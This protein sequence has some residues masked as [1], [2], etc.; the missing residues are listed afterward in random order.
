[1]PT[2]DAGS[3]LDGV[4]VLVLGGDVAARA[5]RVLA[6]LGADVVRL[7]D[8]ERGDPLASRRS[9]WLAWSAGTTVGPATPEE[10]AAL[11]ARADVVIDTPHDDATIV[12]DCATAAPDAVWVRITPFGL[13]GPRAHW[14]ATDHGIMAASGNMYSTGDPS[15]PP[16]HAAEP[17]SHAHS[18]GEAAYAAIAAL[19]SGRPQIIDL[20]MQECV[21]IA[22]MGAIGRYEREGL[23]GSRGGAKI[24]TTREIWRAQDGFVS[25]G[26]R[27]GK[28]RQASMELISKLVRDAGIDEPAL[29]QDWATWHQNR[30][31]AEQLAAMERA[32]GAYFA[33]RTMQE[34]YDIACETNLMLAPANSPKEVY[35]SRQLGARGFFQPL[36]D[37]ARF[38]TPFVHVHRAAPS[39][40][41]GPPRVT[42]RTPLF[43]GSGGHCAPDPS[44]REQPVWHGTRIIEFGSGAAGP[45]ATRYFVE[46]GATVLRV[47]SPSR[48]DF[49]RAMAVGAP[50]NP[51][52]LEGAGMYDSLNCAKRH[53]TLNL[54]HPDAVALVKRLVAEWADAV[55]ENYAPKAMKG[56]GLDYDALAS[57]KPDLVMISACLNGQTGP[58]KDYPGFGGQGSALSGWNWITGWPDLEPVGPFGTITDSLAPRYVA[59]ALA[60]GLLRRQRTGRGCYLDLAQVEAG[61][62][63]LSPWL[64]DHELDG[65]IGM[66]RGNA[67][68]D[69]LV[70]GVYPSVDED[71]VGDRWV[72]IACWTEAQRDALARVIAGPPADDA[73]SA[74]T[75]WRTRLDAAE[76]LQAAGVE[77]VPVQDFGDLQTDPQVLHRD[78]FVARTHPF[79]GPGRYERNGTRFSDATTGYDRAGPTFGQDNAWVLGELLGLSS[80][81]IDALRDS[82]AM[83]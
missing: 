16:L 28:A 2:D 34:L 78:H 13:D 21:F 45:I 59:T 62:W 80:A 51:H 12:L 39:R 56:F 18:A 53:V 3:L 35:A 66:R 65:T 50:G 76:A 1:M 11:A 42:D 17:T 43:E 10:A 19:A 57:V 60:A 31:P 29:D 9:A 67:N 33:T 20:S 58:H 27:G 41:T 6:D 5:G 23:R 26:I 75:S 37:V 52:G 44:H 70:H 82:G 55:A 71:G 24:G 54:K 61:L 38:P 48:P 68:P 32:I 81:A 46:H 25:F 30:A 7:H 49:L 47:E 4:N 74:W 36:G 64:L 14:N 8:P 40:P 73:I 15:R 79:L 69:A 22:N 63:A 83:A 72:A 77:A